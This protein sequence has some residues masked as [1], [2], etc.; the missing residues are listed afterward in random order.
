MGESSK[1]VGS[2]LQ[3]W[4]LRASGIRGVGENVARCGQ[5]AIDL[6]FGYR[7][8]SRVTCDLITTRKWF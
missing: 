6:L 7:P 2:G 1:E 3:S 4:F 5:N 8:I